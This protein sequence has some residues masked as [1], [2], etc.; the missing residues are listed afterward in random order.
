MLYVYM[1]RHPIVTLGNDIVWLEEYE[2]FGLN[3]GSRQIKIVNSK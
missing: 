2:L 1:T 3:I